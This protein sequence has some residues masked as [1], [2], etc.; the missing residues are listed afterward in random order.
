MQ[1]RDY[2]TLKNKVTKNKIEN[3]DELLEY[4]TT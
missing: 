3:E 4:Y 2:I 1:C